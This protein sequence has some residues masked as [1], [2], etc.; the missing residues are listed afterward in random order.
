M[1]VRLDRRSVVAMRIGLCA[2]LMF[3]LSSVASADDQ[4][5]IS[6]KIIPTSA[7]K[8]AEESSLNIE[9]VLTNESSRSIEISPAGVG[10]GE[11]I[12]RYEKGKAQ[13]LRRLVDDFDIDW[14]S[15][16]KWVRI[17]PHKSLAI[18]FIQDLS[19]GIPD[20]IT[21]LSK[22]GVY[23]ISID[24]KVFERTKGGQIEFRGTAESNRAIFLIGDCGKEANQGEVISSPKTIPAPEDLSAAPKPQT[25][26]ILHESGHA[27]PQK[28]P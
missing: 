23:A 4:H 22:T 7:E 21:E 25:A 1:L 15:K 24:F 5:L 12:F 27:D 17:A 14:I 20:F 6:I 19:G 8:C 16:G 2:S 13:S 9:A 3:L 11:W 28:Q 18:T 10:G 26:A